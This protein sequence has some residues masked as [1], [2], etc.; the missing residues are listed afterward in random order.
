M[1]PVL[2]ISASPFVKRVFASCSS[3]GAVRVYDSLN[4]RPLLIFEPGYNEYLTDI[5]W[6]PFR[7]AVFGTISN[8]GNVY[9]YDLA[10]SKSNPAMVLKHTDDSVLASKKAATS[11][12]FNPRQR[13]MLS[14][15]Y[16]DGFVRLY[17]LNYV[18]AN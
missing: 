1:G 18:L 2:G 3:D 9:L 8:S 16:Q 13:D 14:V 4:H 10:A 17:K 7:P 12:R 15:G 5:Q 6:S 11:L